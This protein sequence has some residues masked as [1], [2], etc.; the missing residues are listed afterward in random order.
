MRFTLSPATATAA[1]G[2]LFSLFVEQGGNEGLVAVLDPL[3]RPYNQRYMMWDPLYAAEQ[4][5]AAGEVQASTSFSLYRNYDVKTHRRL[6][7]LND[8]LWATFTPFGNA[9]ALTTDA[10]YS[11][12]LLQ[13]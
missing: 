13:K 3:T 4:R 11:I 12:L 10:K 7:N 8:S 9:S 2:V 5:M 1:D 6:G